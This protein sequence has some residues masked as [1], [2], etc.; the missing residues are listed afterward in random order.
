MMTENKKFRFLNA[1][2]FIAD[3]DFLIFF[4][5]WNDYGYS[6]ICRVTGRKTNLGFQPFVSFRVID[7]NENKSHGH[8]L[9]EYSGQIFSSLP[10]SYV[11]IC[12]DVKGCESL[13]LCL[14][15]TDRQQL[16]ENL[17]ICF[18]DSKE[19]IISQNTEAFKKSV[20]RGRMLEDVI[21]NMEQCKQI[22]ICPF[23][24]KGMIERVS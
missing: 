20:L 5:R 6:N 15:P 19:F 11:S 9:K 12:T 18:P 17:N 23:D 2:S 13:L 22:L 21:V 8:I 1:T 16:I 24:I 7:L 4:E 10:P 14:S 3:A